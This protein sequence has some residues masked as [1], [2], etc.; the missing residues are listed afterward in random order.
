MKR[1]A[2]LQAAAAAIAAAVLPLPRLSTPALPAPRPPVVVSAAR[3]MVVTHLMLQ[4]QP[5]GRARAEIAV[6]GQVFFE[7]DAWAVLNV[8]HANLERC[9]LPVPVVIRVDDPV[10][11]RLAR[12]R[13]RPRVHV[14]LAGYTMPTTQEPRRYQYAM[15]IEAA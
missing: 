1:R 7:R 8:R 4:A 13:G 15:S 2:F 12:V 11:V 9:E 10:E 6:R 14:V 3:A 5:T